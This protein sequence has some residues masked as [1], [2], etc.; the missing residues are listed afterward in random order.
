MFRFKPAMDGSIFDA[1]NGSDGYMADETLVY[2]GG[3]TYH[4]K[5]DVNV[6]D[7]SYSLTITPEGGDPVA[8]ATDYKFRAAADSLVWSSVRYD[9]SEALGEVDIEN[10]RVSS[11]ANTALESYPLR[12][13]QTGSFITTFKATSNIDL[14][15]ATIALGETK[16]AFWSAQA[17]MLR[18][19]ETG[20][21]DVRNGGSYGVENIVTYTA[22]TTYEFTVDANVI[23]QTY[24]VFVKVDSVG[25]TTDTLAIDYAFRPTTP[26]DSIN[27]VTVLVDYEFEY[28]LGGWVTVEDL[29]NDWENWPLL[30]PQAGIF[31]VEFDA[32]PESND[33][34]AVLG[35]S[36]DDAR[37]YGDL[38]SLV[39]FKPEMDGSILDAR[40]GGG[41]AAD[42]D[43]VYEGGKNY[44]FK[45]EVDVSMET[46]DV[47]VTPEYLSPIKL[48]TGYGFRNS[49]DILSWASVRYDRS[50]ALGELSISNFSI[51]FVDAIEDMDG[52]VIKDYE[53][54]QNYPNP[55]NPSTTINFALP[56]SSQVKLLV[57][58]ILGQQVA[59]LVNEYMD[60]G[61]HS[62]T[63][64]ASRYATGL[65]FYR[66][67][68]DNRVLVKK[69][70]L[71][72]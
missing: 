20:W 55:F 4:I 27:Y 52:M 65:Y 36:K 15:N 51:D 40:N 41:Y 29:Q 72:K 46:Y 30:P 62:V 48:A 49:A 42:A 17:M 11:S 56:K 9:R 24:S 32:V 70:M 28:M 2:E 12:N 3:I 16:D 18:F 60:T 19:K 10:F 67:Q 1:R 59:E 8:L 47:T 63:F 31:T 61:R 44:H 45:I 33:L 54:S 25:A 34:N 22:N 5:V 43:I 39:R 69:M 71:I 50:E 68:A 6:A 57:Y 66:L 58:D 53:L 14:I 26:T 21:F 35:M 7:S 13:P 64:D 23:D 37:A 38:S